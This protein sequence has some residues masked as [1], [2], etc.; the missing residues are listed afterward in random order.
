MGT[1]IWDKPEFHSKNYIWPVGYKSTRKLPSTS[2]SKEYITYRSE[3][4][5]GE[6]GP[7]FQVTP[8]DNSN[9][10]FQHATSSGVWVDVLKR[11]KKRSNVSVSGPEVIIIYIYIYN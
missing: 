6:K 10:V 9:L 3:I 1:V 2:N 11:I 5:Y 8:L 4:L 7:I